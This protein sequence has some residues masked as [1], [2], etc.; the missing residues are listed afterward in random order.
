MMHL[1]LYINDREARRANQETPETLGTVHGTELRQTK[2][3]HS[4]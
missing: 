2:Q 1:Y 4:T 3:N